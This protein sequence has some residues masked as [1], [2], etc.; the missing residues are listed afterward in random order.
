MVRLFIYG[1]SNTLTPD[2][3]VKQI[4]NILSKLAINYEIINRGLGTTT[5]I[6]G[7]IKLLDDISIMKDDDI[8]VHEYY[9]NDQNQSSV[10]LINWDTVLQNLET[11]IKI[12]NGRKVISILIK[13][14]P[15]FKNEK[16]I[17][18]YIDILNKYNVSF[19][20]TSKLVDT[21]LS[22]ENIKE[23][24][25]Q[26][27]SGN[28]F[29]HPNKDFYN[30]ISE[31]FFK[32]IPEIHTIKKCD[33]NNKLHKLLFDKNL[34]F[35]NNLVNVNYTITN[36]SNPF[37]IPIKQPMRLMT[38]EYLCDRYSGIIQL[39]TNNAEYYLTT[40]K[41]EPKFIFERNKTLLTNLTFN[42]TIIINEYLEIN[43]IDYSSNLNL[44]S[45]HKSDYLIPK[46]DN[47]IML[48]ELAFKIVNIVTEIL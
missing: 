13:T 23:T 30:L 25:Y 39:K 11:F 22:L 35:T 43:I 2:S 41:N 46:Y 36:K 19:V 18:E 37:H 4:S 48:N 42:Q 5:T 38:I 44:T 26:G 47:D 8:I 10:G 15:D 17:N 9:V 6:I 1:G 34:E 24:F 20:D 27:P 14:I 28:G 45:Y 29:N 21:N 12:A 33:S 40:L 16:Y 7:A 31:Y 3:Y 32:N